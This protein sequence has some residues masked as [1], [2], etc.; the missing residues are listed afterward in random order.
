MLNLKCHRKSRRYL[1]KLQWLRKAFWKG[2]YW[3]QVLKDVYIKI[4]QRER[5]R[6]QQVEGI[7]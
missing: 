7:V 2:R 4:R 6:D 5:E 1:F 3:S